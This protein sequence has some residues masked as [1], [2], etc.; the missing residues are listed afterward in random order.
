MRMIKQTGRERILDRRLFIT[1]YTRQ[2]SQRR[3]DNGHRR[4]FAATQHEITKRQLLIA[5]HLDQSFVKAF[6]ST[7]QPSL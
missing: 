3:V 4:K 2:Q 6:I 7:D 1:E 5:G